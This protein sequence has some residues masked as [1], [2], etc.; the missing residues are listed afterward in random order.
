MFKRPSMIVTVVA[1]L[2]LVIPAFAAASPPSWSALVSIERDEGI[3]S[4]SC[5]PASSFC[6]DFGYVAVASHSE[7]PGRP[8]KCVVPKLKGKTLARAK[9]LLFKTSCRL[10]KVTKPKGNTK[11]MVVV[12]QKPGAGE[13]FRPGTAIAIKLGYRR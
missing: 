8:F 5:A 1:V 3:D 9:R 6:M 2:A 10:G 4:V 12:S 7:P 11:H 13:A